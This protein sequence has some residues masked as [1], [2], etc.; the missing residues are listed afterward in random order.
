MSVCVRVRVCM[1]VFVSVCVCVRVSMCACPYVCVCVGVCMCACPYVCVSVCVCVRV[2][3][4]VYLCVYC[5]SQG[6][7]R[8]LPSYV[9]LRTCVHTY[10][11]TVLIPLFDK[12]T[13]CI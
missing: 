5:W 3:V 1:C 4:C 11:L 2:H 12:Q 7:F 8:G 13:G 6:V 9:Y 10:V